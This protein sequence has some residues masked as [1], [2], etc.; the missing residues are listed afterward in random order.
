MDG[1]AHHHLPCTHMNGAPVEGDGGQGPA[2]LRGEDGLEGG[3][4]GVE[5]FLIV[6]LPPVQGQLLVEI[7][8][9]VKKAD[10]D[11]GYAEVRRRL[12][13]VPGQDP[14]PAGVDGHGLVDSELGTEIGYHPL[15]SRHRSSREPGS[16][17]DSSGRR[18]PGPFCTSAGTRGLGP[19]SASR[20]G[21]A[22]R[23]S[24]M[25]FRPESWYRVG[26]ISQKS[27]GRNGSTARRS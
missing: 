15:R 22:R 2:A 7:P 18:R 12:A 9:Q 6:D 24:S 13:V 17:L 10:S 27:S 11:Q 3:K 25:G 1:S 19:R 16:P 23:R 4:K 20:A 8:L 14:K 21:S 26:S 5:L